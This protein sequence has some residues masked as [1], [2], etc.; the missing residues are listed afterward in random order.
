[1]L[2]SDDR[3]PAVADRVTVSPHPQ[4]QR[5][6]SRIQPGGASIMPTATP[7]TT[8]HIRHR[9][10]FECIALLLQGGGAPGAYG[11]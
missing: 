5:T 1:M 7:R 4:A 9:P 6:P 2:Q 11:P 10:P 3:A 8:H